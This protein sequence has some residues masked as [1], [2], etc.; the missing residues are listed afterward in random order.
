MLCL[1]GSLGLEGETQIPPEPGRSRYPSRG[2]MAGKEKLRDVCAARIVPV[3]KAPAHPR[4]GLVMGK[5]PLGRCLL[6]QASDGF[7]WPP[8]KQ[9]RKRSPARLPA[10]LHFAFLCG[11]EIPQPRPSVTLHACS[12]VPCWDLVLP[13]WSPE[14]AAHGN[15]LEDPSGPLLAPVP[16]AQKPSHGG[17]L[18]EAIPGS[19]SNTASGPWVLGGAGPFPSGPEAT[20]LAFR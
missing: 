20:L 11:P 18:C 13:P 16:E 1:C 5:S 19:T 17:P 6:S 7:P 4:D 10:S 15:P 2:H 3:A 12:L 8:P 14:R 9:T